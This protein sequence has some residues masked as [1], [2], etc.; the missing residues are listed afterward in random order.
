MFASA[1]ESEYE[2]RNVSFECELTNTY[3]QYEPFYIVYGKNC[4][5]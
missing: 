3:I 4:S 2:L 5:E 1:L